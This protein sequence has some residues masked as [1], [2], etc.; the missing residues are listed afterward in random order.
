MAASS[1]AMAAPCAMW[2]F[3][4]WQASPSRT[5]LPSLHKSSGGRVSKG[6]LL[7]VSAASI[8]ACTLG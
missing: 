5:T 6:H 8:I 2:G 1:I 7:I 3:I 4:G